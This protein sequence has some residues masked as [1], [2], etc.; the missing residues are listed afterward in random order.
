MS[1]NGPCFYDKSRSVER[2]VSGRRRGARHTIKMLA[3]HAI[4]LRGLIIQHKNSRLAS[5]QK[6]PYL[7][8]KQILTV[9]T[10]YSKFIIRGE[11]VVGW[12]SGGILAGVPHPQ[13]S[14]LLAARPLSLAV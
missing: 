9:D 5:N 1:E 6:Y 8:C 3:I 12:A 7:A 4:S 11:L 2:A 14:H 10:L 13:L